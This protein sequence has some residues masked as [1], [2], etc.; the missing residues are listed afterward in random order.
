MLP[1]PQTIAFAATET[2]LK[3]FPS[4][5]L[6]IGAGG[7]EP[8]PTLE[9][10]RE[11]VLKRKKLNEA[12]PCAPHPSLLTRS[13]FSMRAA[14]RRDLPPHAKLGDPSGK[15]TGVPLDAARKSPSRNLFRRLRRL[16]AMPQRGIVYSLPAQRFTKGGT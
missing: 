14:F 7:P 10:L 16:A 12:G 4:A 3:A 1:L 13:I 11:A 9:Q 15:F 8:F 5:R 2:G 6:K